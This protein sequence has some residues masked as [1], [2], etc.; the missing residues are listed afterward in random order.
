MTLYS[1]FSKLMRFTCFLALFWMGRFE[2][3]SNHEEWVKSAKPDFATDIG[4][5]VKASIETSAEL[6]PLVLKI[7]DE[8]RQAM[9]ELLKV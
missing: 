7:K 9:D 4:A 6:V 1:N 8:C 3:K 2:F 5:R